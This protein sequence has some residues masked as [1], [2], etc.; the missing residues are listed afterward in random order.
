MIFAIIEKFWILHFK[1]FTQIH[2]SSSDFFLRRNSISLLYLGSSIFSLLWTIFSFFIFNFYLALS[3][4]SHSMCVCVWVCCVYMCVCELVFVCLYFCM[5]LYTLSVSLCVRVC[6]VCMCVCM[7]VAF[8][9]F[10]MCLS[11]CVFAVV[12]C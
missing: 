4:L 6:V 11:E 3:S 1:E 7:C 12:M 10:C 5:F 8:V 2:F 9:C